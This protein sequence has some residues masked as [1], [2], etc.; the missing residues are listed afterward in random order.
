MELTISPPRVEE[1]RLRLTGMSPLMLD[2][3]VRAKSDP[4][5]DFKNRLSLMPG[6]SMP[7]K[8]IGPG[9]FWGPRK[10]TFGIHGSHL[11]RSVASAPLLSR[12]ERTRAKLGIFVTSETGELIPITYK[13]LVM[14]ESVVKAGG[15]LNGIAY[16]RY[17]PMF[18][19]WSVDIAVKYLLEIF[20]EIQILDMFNQAGF[21]VGVGSW[22]PEKGGDRGS[23]RAEIIDG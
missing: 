5:S 12:K 11:K 14:H 8:R 23:F 17:I 13:R 4:F 1:T 16:S 7:K 3:W 10:N 21:A 2:G 19:G 9:G 15:P 6:A 22:R 20:T 18:E